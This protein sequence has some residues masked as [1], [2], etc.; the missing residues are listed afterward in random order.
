M[1]VAMIESVIEFLLQAQNPDGGWGAAPGKRSNTEAT[2]LC[3]LGLSTLGDRSLTP[4]INLGLN[5]LTDRQKSDGSWSLTT[6]LK[7]SSWTT[8][9][10]ILALIPF[11][12]HG[13]KATR[14]ARWLLHQEGGDLGWIASLIYRWVPER[15]P[16]RLNPDLKGWPWTS[17]T[18]S[19]VEPTAYALIAL[20]KLKPYLEETRVEERVREGEL[21]IYDRMC[22]GGGW[23]H[24][25]PEVLGVNLWPYPE[26]TALALIALQDH[27]RAEANRMSLQALRKMLMGVE[28]GLALSWSTLCF[29]LYGHD[30]SEWRERLTNRYAMTGFLG[31]TKT[32]AL[33]LLA[34]GDGPNPFQV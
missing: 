31:E 28:S 8:A 10:A 17:G 14:G 9:L 20:K 12:H 6:H 34:S 19:W 23:N 22:D 32:V 1:A 4:R 29:S 16:V 7:E 27:Q 26:T 30:I 5:W 21:M 2:S 15:L 18:S 13:Q 24:G 11:E 33:A 25:N 3:I